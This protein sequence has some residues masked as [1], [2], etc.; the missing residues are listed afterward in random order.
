MSLSSAFWSVFSQLWNRCNTR[1]LQLEDPLSLSL[2]EQLAARVDRNSS[3]NLCCNL[4]A[5]FLGLILLLFLFCFVSFLL[6]G[7]LITLANSKF[8]IFRFLLQ[9]GILCFPRNLPV[10]P[11]FPKCRPLF[12]KVS[13]VYGV[14]FYLGFS[15]L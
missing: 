13:V 11:L 4:P 1:H 10:L 9:L 2:S 15:I 5:K 14:I 7:S 3:L 6:G 8:K 12:L